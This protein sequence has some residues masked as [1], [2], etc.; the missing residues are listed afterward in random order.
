MK[1]VFISY[2]YRDEHAKEFVGF[3]REHLPALGAEAV[4]IFMDEALPIGEDW[5]T[6]LTEAI[7]RCSVFIC[8]TSEM[9]PNVMFELGYALGKNKEIILVGDS[10]CIPADLQH[11]TYV[12]R[13]SHPY[14]VLVQVQKCLS[15]HGDRRPFLGLDPKYPKRALD[16]LVQRPELLDSLEGG[17]FEELIRH[18][19]LTKGYRVNP[20]WEDTRDYGFD[21]LVEPF[22][23]DR[24]AVEVKKYRTTS[25]VPVSV[26]RQLL[27][28][29]VME[30]IPLGIV[31]SSA[32]FTESAL[33]FARESNTTIL[34][35]TL[36]DL[37][38]MAEI[39][40]EGVDT[41]I[42]LGENVK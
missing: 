2:P 12:P 20:H 4:D 39:P 29:I 40:N 19:F 17:E 5:R 22:R 30:H 38:R 18:W 9:N 8:F 28:A 24:A 36:Q 25:K 37:I 31:I 14:D 15:A 42:S 32:P 10:R 27:G 6:S 34:L 3:L 16:I 13:D 11:M 35:W 21:F 23:G 41:Y 7:N 33:F 26:V 1:Q